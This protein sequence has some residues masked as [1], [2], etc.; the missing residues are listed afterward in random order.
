MG[1]L[2]PETKHP[3]HALS[4][5]RPQASAAPVLVLQRHFC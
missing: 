5:L 4:S 2:V 1:A 3:A